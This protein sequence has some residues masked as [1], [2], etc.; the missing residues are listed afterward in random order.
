MI[1][2]VAYN[3]PV[4][5][6][7]S[8]GNHTITAST[9]VLKARNRLYNAYYYFVEWTGPSTQ[10]SATVTIDLTANESLTACYAVEFAGK[11]IPD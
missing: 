11:V 2:G 3:G 5:V 9:Q 1:D 6:I 4:S 10:T 8:P 7:L